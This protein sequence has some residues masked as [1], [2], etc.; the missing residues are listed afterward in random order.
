MYPNDQMEDVLHAFLPIQLMSMQN[1]IKFCVWNICNEMK[2]R[3]TKLSNICFAY[4][5]TSF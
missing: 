3:S 1:E 5:K 2:I 4:F